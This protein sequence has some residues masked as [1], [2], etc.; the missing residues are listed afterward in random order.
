MLIIKL[1]LLGEGFED[2]GSA[3]IQEARVGEAEEEELTFRHTSV[4]NNTLHFNNPI[5]CILIKKLFMG[6]TKMNK[7]AREMS[8]P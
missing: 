6:T 8:P 7:D 3:Y 2:G 1:T 5:Q 4:L